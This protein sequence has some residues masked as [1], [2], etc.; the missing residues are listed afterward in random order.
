MYTAEVKN[1]LPNPWGLYDM[2]GNVWEWCLDRA[3]Y[4]SGK[5]ITNTY[6]DDVQ[7]PLCRNGSER[8][9]R[10]GSWD[11]FAGLCRSAYRDAYS[12]GYTLDY[13]GFRVVLAPV[14]EKK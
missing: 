8:V 2:H 12:P 9:L 6:V 11:Y 13:V 10:G 5:V 4:Q 1:L 14:Q 7:D 3:D